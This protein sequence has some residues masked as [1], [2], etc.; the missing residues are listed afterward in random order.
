MNA[1]E[2]QDHIISTLSANLVPMIVGSPGVGKSDIIRQIAK[3]F[4]LFVIDL[5]LSQCDPTDMLGFPTH[6]GVRMAYAPPQHFPLQGMDEPPAGFDGWL[7]F[8]DEFSSAPLAV[9]AAAYKVVLDKQVGIYPLHKKVAI[10]CAGNKATDNAIVSRLSTAMQSRLVHLPL[11]PDIKSWV[12]W[13]TGNGI[14]HRIVSYLEGRPEHLHQFK[15]DHDDMTFACPRTWEFASRLILNK[16]VIPQMLNLLIGTLSAG[17]AHEFNAYLTF[18]ADLP[19]IADIKR[20]PAGIEIPHEPALLYATSH[21]VAAHID[22][23]DAPA[24]MTYIDRLPLEFG[25]TAARAALK[26]NKELLK[27]PAMRAWADKVAAEIF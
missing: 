13:A 23:H 27:L 1:A 20:N 5:R 3:K 12:S 11:E 19:S 16:P 15:P 4:R 24:L 18:C 2:L 25:T 22:E 17:I 14:D 7:L 21:M 8:L 6:N 26:R 9:Q 10:V